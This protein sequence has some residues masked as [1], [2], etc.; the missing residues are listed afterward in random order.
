M[1]KMKKNIVHIFL[2][3]LAT[4]AFS[5]RPSSSSSTLLGRTASLFWAGSNEEVLLST[6]K[7]RRQYHP[8]RLRRQHNTRD[9]QFHRHH[10]ITTMSE[11]NNGERGTNCDKMKILGVC[12][13]I[14]SGKSTACQLMVDSLG[15]AACIGECVKNA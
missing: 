12:G 14:G 11:G 5:T 15:C 3:P 13:G 2:L 10:Q 4:A 7:H 1:N 6:P 8:N 9:H